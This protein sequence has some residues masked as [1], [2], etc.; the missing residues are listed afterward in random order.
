MMVQI[1]FLNQQ[2]DNFH[3]TSKNF[4]QYKV[5]QA[6]SACSFCFEILIESDKVDSV[7]CYFVSKI[8]TQISKQPFW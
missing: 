3:W 7:L 1:G 8:F 6:R 4:E 5:T 2:L